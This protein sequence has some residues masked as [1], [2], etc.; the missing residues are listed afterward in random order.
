VA[1]IIDLRADAVRVDP[2]LFAIARTDSIE[3]ST[4][5]Y[6]VTRMPSICSIAKESCEQLFQ[7]QNITRR[8]HPAGAAG[9]VLT[10]GSGVGTVGGAAVGSEVGK[11][12][13]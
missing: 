7:I 13:K 9:S 6:P 1:R 12:K 11:E 4:I 10:G 2:H 3:T 8:C 5:S